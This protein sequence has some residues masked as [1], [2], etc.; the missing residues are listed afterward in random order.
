MSMHAKIISGAYENC[1]GSLDN[2]VYEDGE[3]NWGV[4]FR[5]DPGVKKCPGCSKFFWNE[6]AVLECPDCK[7]QFGDGYKA[8]EG[9]KHE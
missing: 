8:S 7:I 4:L 1:F 9:E 5:A 3:P 6:A 2:A